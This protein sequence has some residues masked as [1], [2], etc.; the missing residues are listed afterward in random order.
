VF[1]GYALWDLPF[2]KKGM[3]GRD[4]PAPVQRIIEGWN[5][6]GVVTMQTGR[7]FTVYSGANQMSNVLN[8]TANCSGCSREMGT[9]DKTSSVFGGV[10]G[11]FTASELAQ[12]SQPAAGELGN[13]GR[14]YFNGPGGWNVDFA[15]LKRTTIKENW[16]LELR[17]EFF[18]VFNHA[19]FGF[20]TAIANST[21]FGRV[22]DSIVNESRKVRIGAKINF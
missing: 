13:T 20:P 19:N 8:S 21:T 18:N 3:V 5:V 15:L 1:V 12:F 17:F 16:N 11:Y 22:R 14:N 7:P 4:A 10:P 9:L 6:N 2:G